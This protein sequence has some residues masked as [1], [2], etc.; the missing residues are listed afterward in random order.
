[1][2]SPNLIF[3]HVIKND[4]EWWAVLD[5]SATFKIGIHGRYSMREPGFSC[6]IKHGLLIVHRHSRWDFATGAIDTE[7]MRIASLAHDALCNMYKAGAIPFSVRVKAN[8]I[9]RKI[10]KEKGCPF[11]R[12]WYAFFAVSVYTY[13]REFEWRIIKK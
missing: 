13:L 2:I 8:I 5:R 3:Y 12:R 1:M 9:F 10:L 7:D 4:G 6:D 11:I